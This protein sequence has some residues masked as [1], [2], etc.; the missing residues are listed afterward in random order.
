MITSMA[1][2][3]F[4]FM[5][6]FFSCFFVSTLDCQ[7]PRRWA[8]PQLRVVVLSKARGDFCLLN[9][10][11]DDVCVCVDHESTNSGL[12]KLDLRILDGIV[13]LGLGED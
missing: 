1:V 5:F 10:S 9:L 7:F 4:F 11:E 2:M 6:A 13:R 8:S 3:F 12:E